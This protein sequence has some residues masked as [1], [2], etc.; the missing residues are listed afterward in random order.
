[1]PRPCAGSCLHEGLARYDLRLP[2]GRLWYDDDPS[3]PLEPRGDGLGRQDEEPDP[4][5]PDLPLH[6]PVATAALDPAPLTPPGSDPRIVASPG[7]PVGEDPRQDPDLVALPPS[8]VAPG[9]PGAPRG[10][11]VEGVL[12]LG[13][14]LAD[15]PER[16]ERAV[17]VLPSRPD[18]L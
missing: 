13:R 8:E 7:E 9:R 12:V 2:D 17:G 16:G 10:A 1:M 11:V 18:G 15:G 6:G 4:P 14:Q 5:R 3:E